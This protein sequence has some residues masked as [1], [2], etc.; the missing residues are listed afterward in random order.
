MYLLKF[1][2]NNKFRF[3]PVLHTWDYDIIWAVI[4]HQG[5]DYVIVSEWD[6][7]HP[8]EFYEQTNFKQEF[9]IIWN[10]S[11]TIGFRTAIYD[12]LRT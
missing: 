8:F 4:Y 9:N 6:A 2:T 1:D 12:V 7:Y 11:G 10:F 3:T 5:V